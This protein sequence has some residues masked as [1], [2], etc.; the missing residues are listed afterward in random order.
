MKSEKRMNISFLLNFI[1]TI[2]EFL[3]GILTN[4]IALI[5][6]AI[7]NL[8]DSITLALA[9]V[10]ERKSKNKPDYLYTYGYYRFS[11]LGGLI[12]AVIL[13]FGSGII[14]FEAIKR[15]FEPQ[16][17]DSKLLIVFAIIGV[18]TNSLAALIVSKGK[19]VNE[20]VISLHL[21]EDVF[22]WIVLLIGAVM[23]NIFGI[24]YLDSLLSIFFALFIIFHVYR[25][26]KEILHVFLERVPKGYS[27][28]RIRAN[29][30]EEELVK[31]IHHIHLW[32]IEGNI[33]IITCHALIKK[34]VTQ[35]QFS[36][37]QERLKNR[38]KELKILHSTIQMEFEEETCIG[39]QCDNLEVLNHKN[40]NH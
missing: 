27:I 23:M 17:I 8:G 2:F 26:I 28:E 19:S 12:S 1:F 7:H 30:E 24:D 3:G 38:L 34:D 5:S 35:D 22:G 32:T 11:L 14:I 6:D 18:V 40:H 33:P 21:F 4:S 10:L 13:V 39:E 9:I 36:N 31:N 20:K 29:L 16:A 37:L 25:N 15:L